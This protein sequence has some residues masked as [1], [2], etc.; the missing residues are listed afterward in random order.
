M[1]D[2]Y[3]PGL[4]RERT[5]LAWNRTGLSFVVLGAVALRYLPPTARPVLRLALGG[6]MVALGVFTW[7]YGRLR[8]RTDPERRPAPPSVVRVIAY[9]TTFVATMAVVLTFTAPLS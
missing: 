3:D 5:V 4:A 9:G 1:S 7:S 6:A 8:V 2:W